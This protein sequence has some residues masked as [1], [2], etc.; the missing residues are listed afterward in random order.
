MLEEHTYT[1]RDS[2]EHEFKFQGKYGAKG[3]K[4][5]KR[6]K[7]TPEQVKR[8]NQWNKENTVRRTIK[9]NFSEGDL[10]VTLKY[11]KGTRKTLEEVEADVKRFIDQMRKEYK[12]RGQPFK[13]IRRIEIG[14]RGGIHAHMIMN[15]IAGADTDLIAQ[16]IW[17]KITGGRINYSNL[18]SAGGYKKLAK[19]ITKQ[20]NEEQE[21]QLSVFSTAERK[22]LVKYSSS[23]NLIRPQP[24]KKKSHWRT[25]RRMIKD[26][27]KPKEGYYVDPESVYYGINPFNGMTY[28]KYTE[29]RLGTLDGTAEPV[30][31]KWRSWP[32]EEGGS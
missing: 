25:M 26:G 12:K 17:S 7:A 24:V 4:R 30:K 22:K 11:P 8:Q 19:Y 27:I 23:K 29:C 6:K 10:W 13:W 32:D 9:G 20:P 5:A 14:E 16:G 2:I 3:E 1:Y 15:R 28:L 21:K 18:Y 31:P